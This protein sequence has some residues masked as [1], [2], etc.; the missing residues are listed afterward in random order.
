[1]VNFEHKII[2]DMF[3]K[4]DKFKFNSVDLKRH[5]LRFK[6]E[7]DLNH[8][9]V[10]NIEFCFVDN[11]VYIGGQKDVIK[12]FDSFEHDLEVKLFEEDI[13]K[14]LN[15]LQ[16]GLKNFKLLTSVDPY[17]K[18]DLNEDKSSINVCYHFSIFVDLDIHADIILT[19]FKNNLLKHIFQNYSSLFNNRLIDNQDL[20][21]F[22]N[23]FNSTEC[24]ES[25]ISNYFNI[26]PNV[27]FNINMF[28]DDF[29]KY[30][31]FKDEAGYFHSV[32]LLQINYKI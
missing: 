14:I 31:L 19:R 25:F 30:I 21:F 9:D 28:N 10:E 26:D 4:N 1:M 22:I 7:D 5:R 11:F 27:R 6:L 18:I 12:N 3:F 29:L 17:L 23:A 20:D 2:E 13:S 15:N 16:I 32:E 8:F 24:I